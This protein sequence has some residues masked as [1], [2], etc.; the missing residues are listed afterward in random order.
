MQLI[1]SVFSI[2]YPEMYGQFFSRLFFSF[3]YR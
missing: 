3:V 1:K 2:L